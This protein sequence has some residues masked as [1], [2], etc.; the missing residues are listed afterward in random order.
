M[1]RLACGRRRLGGELRTIVGEGAE[2]Q[3][4]EGRDCFLDS[5]VLARR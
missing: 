1:F 4:R 5:D 3:G 2:V